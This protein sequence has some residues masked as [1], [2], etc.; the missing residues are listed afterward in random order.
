MSSDATRIDFYILADANA[1]ARLRFACKLTEKAY[2]SETRAHAHMQSAAAARELDEMLWTFRA[3]SFI[4]H[5][6]VKHDAKIEVPVTIGS[7]SESIEQGQL[8]INLADEIPVFFDKYER[9]AEIIDGTDDCK[10][11]G[12]KRFSFYRDNG[13]MPNTHNIS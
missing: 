10:A 7:E 2:K 11:L 1:G 9:I 13:Y 8:L 6:L 4:P 3:G 12:R 5:E